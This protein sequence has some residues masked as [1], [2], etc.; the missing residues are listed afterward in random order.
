MRVA[1]SARA[2]AFYGT[3]FGWDFTPGRSADAWEVLEP[4]P[5]IGMSGGHDDAVTVPA[6]RVNDIDAAV[7][8][9]R[10]AGGTATDPAPQPYGIRAECTDD[11]S[12]SFFLAQT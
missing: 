8:R 6:Y 7:E 3:V 2:R 11:Q 5:P 4:V 1:D 12:T 9:V 10:S